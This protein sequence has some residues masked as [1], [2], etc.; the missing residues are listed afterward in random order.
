MFRSP[1]FSRFI[2]A[3]V[4]LHLLFFASILFLAGRMT[5]PLEILPVD[6]VDLPKDVIRKLPP[7]QPPKVQPVPKAVALPPVPPQPVQ[8]EQILPPRNIPAP[9]QFGDAPDVSVPKTKPALGRPEGSEQGKSE[10]GKGRKGTE[11]VTPYEKGGPLPFLSQTDID[12]LAK[13]GMPDSKP[14]EN[15]VTL[16]T[17][18]FKFMSYN[19][20]LKIKVESVLKYPE[21]AAMS[22]LQGTLYIK[23]DIM[24]DG[25]LG[26]LELLK[27]SGY[28]ILDDEALRAIRNAAPFQPLPDDWKMERYSIR[29]AVLFYLSEAY[30]R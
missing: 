17:N 16:D 14:G 6:I 9:K 12:E 22:G 13:K 1:H 24:K 21:L 15:S 11:G 8:P 7:L 4:G 28:K 5:K 29:A 25:S 19:R 23:F 20:W 27:S 26:D 30:V 3:S 18:E 2:A 10:T